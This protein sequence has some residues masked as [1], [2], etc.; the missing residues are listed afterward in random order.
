MG[1]EWHFTPKAKYI[2]LFK[3]FGFG[4]N[5]LNAKITYTNNN[6]STKSRRDYLDAHATFLELR[7]GGVIALNFKFGY[8]YG[9]LIWKGG[10]SFKIM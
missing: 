9:G 10:L 1:Y 5:V 4:Y 7:M 6:Y 3:G 2:D 8:A